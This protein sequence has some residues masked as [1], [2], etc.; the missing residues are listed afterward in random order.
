MSFHVHQNG[1]FHIQPTTDSTSITTGSFVCDGGIGIAKTITCGSNIN[2]GSSTQILGSNA[3]IV[4][5]GSSTSAGTLLNA[6]AA[7]NPTK[8]LP[9]NDN[10]VT[11]YIPSW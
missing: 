4:T 5:S 2:S 7:G 11:R 10:G 8:W 3:T 6:P 1:T 9:Y